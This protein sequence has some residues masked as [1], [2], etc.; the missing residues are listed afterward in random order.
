MEPKESSPYKHSGNGNDHQDRQELSWSSGKDDTRDSMDD[1][2]GRGPLGT[3]LTALT[4][5]QARLD[6]LCPSSTSSR[7]F[8]NVL[9][10]KDARSSQAPSSPKVIAIPTVAARVLATSFGYPPAIPQQRRRRCPMVSSDTPR[11]RAT[12]TT[13]RTVLYQATCRHTLGTILKASHSKIRKMEQLWLCFDASCTSI[14]NANPWHT[15]SR[16]SAIFRHTSL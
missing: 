7:F 16:Q 13:T 4:T 8:K 15:S 10:Y 12:A 9:A 14:A 6:L 5:P 3:I 1:K 11:T 2:G